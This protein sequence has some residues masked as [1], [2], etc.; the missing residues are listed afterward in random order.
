[1]PENSNMKLKQDRLVFIF[2]FQYHFQ[3]SVSQ[4]TKHPCG[5]P[6]ISMERVQLISILNGKQSLPDGR[7]NQTKQQN[8]QLPC[9]FSE[10]NECESENLKTQLFRVSHNSG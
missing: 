3:C 1:M 10:K 4:E 5:E 9:L 2:Q 6:A 7:K 8:F